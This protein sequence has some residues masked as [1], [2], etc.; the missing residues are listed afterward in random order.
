MNQKY[1]IVEKFNI[2]GLGAVVVID[3]ITDRA[4]K[5]KY[6]VEVLTVSGTKLVTSAFKEWLLRREAKP[7]EKECYCLKDLNAD[8]IATGSS[9]LFIQS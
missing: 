6:R 4:P 2:N 9:L 8:K 5:Q 1:K 7:M 3:E